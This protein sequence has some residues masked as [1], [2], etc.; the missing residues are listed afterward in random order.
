MFGNIANNRYADSLGPAIRDQ[1][2]GMGFNEQNMA[3]LIAAARTNTAAAYAAVPGINAQ[4]QAAAT[5]AN[6]EAYLKG[7][8]MAYYVALAFGFL[9]CIIALFIPSIDERKYT[10]RTVAVQEADR[11]AM[12]DDKVVPSA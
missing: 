2:A 3:R 6:K 12:E 8:Q 11:K 1:I 10:K 5:Y 7:T 9:G 4:I